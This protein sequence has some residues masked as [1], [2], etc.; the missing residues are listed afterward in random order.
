MLLINPTGKG[1][2]SDGWGNGH[3]GA[4]RRDQGKRRKHKGTD[5]VVVPGQRIFAPAN[6]IYRRIAY[7]YADSREYTGG[8]FEG[9]DISYKIYYYKSTIKPGKKVLQGDTIGYSQ[10]ISNRYGL[11]RNGEK[12]VPHIHLEI[13]S[14][15]P[16]IL[17]GVT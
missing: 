1:V 10:D 11:D 5:Y 2:R 3:F 12:M 13:T 7:P 15:N 8:Y 16:E 4:T 17:M 6:A 9:E 14:I